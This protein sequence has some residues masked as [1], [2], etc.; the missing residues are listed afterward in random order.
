MSVTSLNPVILELDTSGLSC[1]LPI[2]K[3]RKAIGQLQK[4]E[5]LRLLATDHGSQK[6]IESFCKQTGNALLSSNELE[7][8]Y[9][10]LIRKN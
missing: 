1:P 2:L 4:G 3:T 6:D 10:F 8:A 9:E 5:V 7:G